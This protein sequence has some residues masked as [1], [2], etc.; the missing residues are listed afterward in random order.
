MHPV[1]SV[2]SIVPEFLIR[3]SLWLLTHSIYKFACRSGHLPSRGPALLSAITCRTSTGFWWAL[4]PAVHRFMV[5]PAVLRDPRHQVAVSSHEG[6]SGVGRQS[7]GCGRSIA[8]ARA[9]LQ[10]GHVVCIFAEGASAGPN[11]IRSSAATNACRG[12]GRAL[13]RSASSALGT[14]QLQARSLFWKLGRNACHVSV[15]VA[16]GRNRSVAHT[17]APRRVGSIC[18]ARLRTIETRFEGAGKARLLHD[19]LREMPD[20]TGRPV[21]ERQYWPSATRGRTSPQACY[22]RGGCGKP[23]REACLACCCRDCRG[24]AVNLGATL[25]GRVP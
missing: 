8:R 24:S 19:S 14:F 15:T 9:E 20:A 2:L 3:F 23:S 7:T 22:W 13:F 5:V 11:L 17:F 6:H 12:L 25:A 10:A 16:F 1:L 4:P 21:H 18:V